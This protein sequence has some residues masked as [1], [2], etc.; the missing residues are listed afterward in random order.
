MRERVTLGRDGADRRAAEALRAA[1][2]QL[3]RGINVG[4]D[5][6][7][8]TRWLAETFDLPG[9]AYPR[10]A[11]RHPSFTAGTSGWMHKH[12]HWLPRLIVR[13]DKYNNAAVNVLE[14]YILGHVVKGRLDAEI[15]PHRS[16][17][18]GARSLRLS[19][20]NPPLQLMPAH[21]EEMAPS[22]RGVFLPAEGQIWASADFSR[23]GGELMGA[24]PSGLAL[25]APTV[26]AAAIPDCV[27][28]Q[29]KRYDPNC[30]ESPRL[31]GARIGDPSIKKTPIMLRARAWT[32]PRRAGG[33]TRYV[34]TAPGIAQPACSSRSIDANR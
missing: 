24:N 3:C 13:A 34:M 18:G 6:I 31:W 29:V 1:I 27:Q 4:M 28:I 5:E 15:R 20:S 7:G 30:L 2:G 16:D 10:T 22:I 12:E 19:Y 11:K 25:C 33:T 17:A 8:H 26:C 32:F 9:I 23:E 21:D 14:T